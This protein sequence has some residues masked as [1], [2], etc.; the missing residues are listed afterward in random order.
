MENPKQV[1]IFLVDD[2]GLYL[3][4]LEI[5][6]LEHANFEIY[7]YTSGEE[8]IQNLD[9]K[10]QLIILDYHLDG[11]NKQAL[12]GIQAL[13]EIKKVDPDI[14]IVIFS[15]QDKIEVAVECMHHKAYDYVVKSETAFIRIK[16]IIDTISKF[17]HMES[18]LD[19]YMDRM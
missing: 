10:P 4:L 14:P 16:H 7:A 12:T 9:K 11:V 5:E 8:C 17:N 6:F 19:W 2:D 15:A 1:K 18:Q 3:K 13:D